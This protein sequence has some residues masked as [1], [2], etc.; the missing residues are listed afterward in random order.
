M[1]LT[2]ALAVA[3]VA[4]GPQQLTRQ[5][6]AVEEQALQRQVQLWE[7]SLNSVKPD[8]IALVYQRSP[9]FSAAWPDGKRTRGWDEEEQAQRDFA[10]RT[11]A[12]NFDVQ[13]PV[14][15]VLS[16]NV[17]LTTFGHTTDIAD[18]VSGR[19]LYS[20]RGTIVWVKDPTDK[21]WKIHTLQVSRTPAPAAQPAGRRR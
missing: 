2:V 3:L 18:S 13:D 21:V 20:G 8:S 17:A 19:A 7:Q 10:A 11:T 4:C 12:Y 15:E 6:L 16:P 14:I 5:E 9:A 1:V